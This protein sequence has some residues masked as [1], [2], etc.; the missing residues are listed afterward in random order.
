MIKLSVVIPVLNEEPLLIELIRQVT[1]NVEIITNDYEV[2]I[3]DDGS[4]D[5]TWNMIRQEGVKN[6]KIKG[7]KFSRNFGHHYAISAG[8]QKAESEWTVVMDGDLQDRPEIIPKLYEK[9]LEGF[10]IV[11]VSRENRPESISYRITQKIYYF[12]LNLLSGIKFDSK[13][14][15]FSI[16]NKKVVKAFNN[17]PENARFYGSTINWLGFN[18]THISADHGARYLGKPSYTFKKR[19]K[20]AADVVLAF[21]DRPLKFAISLG[22]LASTFGLLM[23]TFII[24]S[25]YKWGYAATGWSS[26]ISIVVFFSGNI[27]IVLGIIGLY[28]GRIFA[29]VKRR[30]LFI[31]SETVNLI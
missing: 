19:L 22:I 24:Y 23:A 3:I 20:L 16:I 29:E 6:Q 31:A 2:I 1:S 28:I 13:Q 14:A 27:L 17:F 4:V 5:N 8:L 30:P 12:L 18:R 9:A 10:D 11:F 7:I 15:N 26:L 21:S 25:A